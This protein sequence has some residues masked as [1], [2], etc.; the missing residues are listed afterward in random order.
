MEYTRVWLAFEFRRCSLESREETPAKGRTTVERRPFKRN[1]EDPAFEVVI[2]MRLQLR[3]RGATQGRM[4][5]ELLALAIIAG[6]GGFIFQRRQ[7]RYTLREELIE[8]INQLAI[9]LDSPR[10]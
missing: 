6:F 3:R 9:N 7:A 10:A 1:S 4:T 5:F 8:S 2:G